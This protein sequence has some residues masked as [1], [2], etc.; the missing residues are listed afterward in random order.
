MNP[1]FVTNANAAA[2]VSLFRI[3]IIA[4]GIVLFLRFL[5]ANNSER[6]ISFSPS[7]NI[8]ARC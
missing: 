1:A 5:Y 3:M 8:G 6:Q 2:T 4:Y 7:L